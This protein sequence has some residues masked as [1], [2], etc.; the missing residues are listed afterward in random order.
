M[1]RKQGSVWAATLHESGRKCSQVH[2]HGQHKQKGVN[3]R[4]SRGRKDDGRRCFNRCG[5][6]RSENGSFRVSEAG[7]NAE[8]KLACGGDSKHGDAVRWQMVGGHCKALDEETGTISP[9]HGE[10]TGGIKNSRAYK[11]I[12]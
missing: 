4:I 10:V 3:E 11:S 2:P 6:I 7:V 9:A 12:D 1:T 8:A 5:Q